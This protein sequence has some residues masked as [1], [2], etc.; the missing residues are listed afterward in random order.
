MSRWLFNSKGKPIAFEKDNRV[1]SR[2]GRLIGQLNDK[3]QVWGVGGYQGEIVQDDRFLYQTRTGSYS[4]PA[5]ATVTSTRSSS[6]PSQPPT[7]SAIALP[8]AYRDVEV[9]E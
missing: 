2:K 1:F 9:E 8:S 7:K 3:Q 5:R 4:V 6:I